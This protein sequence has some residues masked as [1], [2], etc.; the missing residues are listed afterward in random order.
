MIFAVIFQYYG[1]KECKDNIKSLYA[2]NPVAA[3]YK[4]SLKPKKNIGGLKNTVRKKSV[5]LKEFKRREKRIK[6]IINNRT[7]FK[8]VL[9]LIAAFCC[10]VALIIMFSLKITT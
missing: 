7:E 10:S 3:V 2:D 9:F 8:A 4:H 1:E 5:F 6:E